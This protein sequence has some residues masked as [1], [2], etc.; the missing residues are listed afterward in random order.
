MFHFPACPS[1]PYEFR[2]G[3]RPMVGGL[4]HSEIP[5]S[6]LVCQLP[7][8]YRRL[9]RPSSAFDAKTSTIH[10]FQLAP[11]HFHSSDHSSIGIETLSAGTMNPR[12]RA[13]CHVVTAIPLSK[14]KQKNCIEG[15]AW[16]GGDERTR[17]ANPQLAKLVLS[18]LSYI[19][20][21][22]YMPAC[23][24]GAPSGAALAMVGLTGVEPVTFPLSGERSSQLSYRPACCGQVGPTPD[25]LRLIVWGLPGMREQ[26]AQDP[27]ANIR[28][29]L[30]QARHKA[31]ALLSL[32]RR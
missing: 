32:E 29:S 21:A 15:P 27:R 14:S 10:P 26:G 18:R 4:L 24:R 31:A 23:R 2:I 1:K 17:T 22:D 7:E 28:G 25:A 9:P 8:A 3:C 16:S 19:P 20:T 12:R 5:G 13:F 11:G 30:D 6:K